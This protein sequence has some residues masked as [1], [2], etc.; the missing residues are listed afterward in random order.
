MLLAFFDSINDEKVWELF[1]K[2]KLRRGKSQQAAQNLPHLI[3]NK[4]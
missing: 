1:E 3:G 2:F 4:L